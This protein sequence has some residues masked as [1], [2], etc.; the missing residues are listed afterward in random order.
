MEHVFL[1]FCYF[2]LLFV[3]FF[4]KFQKQNGQKLGCNNFDD[5][6]KQTNKQTT[7]TTII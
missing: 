6:T 1:G 7:T 2:F 3:V 5:E 4:E